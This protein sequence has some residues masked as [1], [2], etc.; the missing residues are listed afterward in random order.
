[1]GMNTATINPNIAFLFI[2]QQY[3]KTIA[4]TAMV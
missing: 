2:I 1:M 4:K 3:K